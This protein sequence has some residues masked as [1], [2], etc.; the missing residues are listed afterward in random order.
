MTPTTGDSPRRSLYVAKQQAGK[1]VLVTQHYAPFPSATSLYMTEIAKALA[2]NGRTLVITS[3]PDSA[4]KL[5]PKPGEPEV[6]EI[7]SWWPQKSALISRSLAA[8]LFSIQVFIAVMKHTRREDVLL[9]VTNPFTLP[10]TVALAAR[11]RKAASAV[12]IHDL[13]P[14]TLVMVGFLSASSILTKFLRSANAVMFHWLDAV[15]VIG[16]DM[17]SKLLEYPRMTAAKV[18]FIPNWAT[19]PVRYREIDP[20]NPHR[21]RCGGRFV[22]AMSGNAG[23]THDPESV[24]EAARI[25]Q[26]NADIKFL[27]SGEGVGW[28]RLNEM[29]AASP[30]PNV[31]L[32]ERVPEA[33]LESFLSAGDI[34]I[35]PYRKNNTGVSVPS[36]IY[37]QLAVGRP[38][39]I[40][41][42][43]DAEA[44]ML[45]R[46]EDIGWVVPPEDPEA[47]AQVISL[48]AST[49]ANT[50]EKGHRAAIVASR[51]S[52]QISLNAYRDLMDALLDRQLSRIRGS[53][54]SSAEQALW[55]RTSRACHQACP[56][57]PDT[58][59]N[60]GRCMNIW[61]LHPFAGGPGLGRHW[62]PYWLADA[63]AKMGHRPLV[64]SAAFHH[65]HRAPGA[66]GPRR[67]GDVDFW[68]VEVP[69]YDAGS[70]GRL[71]NNLSFGPRFRLNAT[72]IAK[73]FGKPDLIIASSPHLFFVSAAHRVAQ[74]FDAKFWVEVRDLWPESI[75]EL[76]LTPAWHPLVKILRWKERSAYRAADRVI[77]LLAGAEAHMRSRGLPAGRFVWVPNGVSDSEIQSA[78]K[79]QDLDHPLV[80]RIRSMK[81]QGRRAVLYAGSMGPP[82]GVEV[83]V[84]AASVLSRTNPEI[85][86]VLIGSGTS[87]AE[88]KQR[89]AT[90]PNLEFHDEVDRSIV[91]G[92]LHA[93]DCAVM[94]VRKNALFHHGISP[95]KL[96]DYCLFAP[97]SVIACEPKV[98]T[99]LERLVTSRCEPDN[100][101]AL[102]ETIVSAL[103]TPERPLHERVAVAEQFS[104]SVLA[105]RYLA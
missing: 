65:L 83:I 8:V 23:F 37:N 38:I 64:V 81:R 26:N 1:T 53:S 59:L 30:L 98:L 104:Y 13:Y 82:N 87:R 18:N 24:F 76:G 102:A 86:F 6:I 63:W 10:Y 31:T 54:K 56:P 79:T 57:A 45:M 9:C 84:D 29:Q 46:E 52:R 71:W 17:S 7:R 89:A 95:N 49:A 88:L 97:R 68:F 90:L 48:A 33:E 20:E 96:F 78:L 14:D 39:I 61:L 27:F 66:T 2:Q 72:S 93:S 15:V 62:R 92:M 43:P 41:S 4:S 16:R 25:L 50:T 91:H 99:S 22:V 85:Y 74:R 35:V 105:E 32:I 77:S 5:P 47:I 58:L 28:T 94:A 73:Q 69:L 40:C 103:R 34:W 75:T 55:D 67:I 70:L 19:L 60:S 3:S 21:R 12:I 80:E 42:E 51:F 101:A 36:R 100:P 11:L 44:A